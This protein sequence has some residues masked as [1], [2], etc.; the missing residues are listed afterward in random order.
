MFSQ[1]VKLLPVT[2]CVQY[3]AVEKC[4]RGSSSSLY[5]TGDKAN[6]SCA[7][8][9]PYIDLDE[10]FKDTTT[11][12][13]NLE[14]RGMRI[15]IQL[16]QK[17][18]EQF[19][20]LKKYKSD[21]SK[22]RS[23]ILAKLRASKDQQ[24]RMIDD[25]KTESSSLGEK[26]QIASKEL[27]AVE[28]TAC[29]LGLQLPNNIHPDTPPND[30]VKIIHEFGEKPI[31]H[32]HICSHVEIAEKLGLIDYYDSS[33]YFLKGEAAHFE[34]GISNFFM[35]ELRNFGFIPMSNSDFGRSVVVEGVGFDSEDA[36]SI[37]TL[38]KESDLKDAVA[39]LHLVGGASLA[40]FSA[41]HT[42]TST[43][44]K[45][46]P[47]RYVAIGRHYNPGSDVGLHGLFSTWQSSAVE[48]YILAADSNMAMNE[49]E[50][51]VKKTLEIYETLGYHFRIEYLP[52]KV[53]RPWESLRA[54]FQMYSRNLKQY[55]EVG[56]WS[57]CNDYISK[58]L[59]ICCER[60]AG[61]PSTFAHTVSGTVVSIPRLLGCIL[62]SDLENFK[63][64]AQVEAQFV[65]R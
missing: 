42:K 56:N 13:K 64:P 33:Y 15:D 51:S 39:R 29:L 30:T 43:R 12:S 3:T 18:W 58:R 35:D 11:L 16:L 37:F 25:L 27:W 10:R 52:P 28:R 31:C 2:R 5:V 17:N 61:E 63:L 46:L 40:S 4:R 1:T 14:S 65:S 62:E 9:T 32:E 8:L 22:T 50:T 60:K 23:V 57:L 54:S 26:L 34:L 45:M 20:S 49:F 19:K 59:L 48:S 24:P 41:Y 38:E 55:V 36:T 44:V 7:V 6:Q 53:L 21:L 47:L